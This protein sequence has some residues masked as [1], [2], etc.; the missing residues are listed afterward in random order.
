MA[1]IGV[2]AAKPA[3]VAATIVNATSGAAVAAK[4]A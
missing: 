1:T 2:R 4:C 3:I